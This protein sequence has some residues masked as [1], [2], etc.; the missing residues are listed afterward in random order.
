MVE[1]LGEAKT[2]KLGLHAA[3]DDKFLEKHTRNVT[4][5]TESSYNPAKLCEEAKAIS[6][7]LEGIVEYVLS[8][9]FIT[10]YIHKFQ[11]VAKV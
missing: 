8:A 6:K 10:V 7:P 9:S 5:F 4:Y 11:T 2:K 3:Q 1:A